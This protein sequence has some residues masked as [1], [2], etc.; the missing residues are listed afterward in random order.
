[1]IMDST[2]SNQPFVDRYLVV[3]DFMPDADA[4]AMRAAIEAHFANP[5]R[6]LPAT[7]MV[8]NYWYVPGLYTYLRAEPDKVLGAKLA[9]AFHDRLA[10]WSRQTLGLSEVTWSC[11]SLYIPGCRQGQHN[12]SANGRFGF[13]YSL[14]RNDRKTGGGETLIW[15]EED[16]FTTRLQQPHAGPGFYEAIVPQFNR[17]LVFDDRVPHAVQLVEGGMNPIEGRIVLHGHLREAGPIVEGELPAEDVGEIVGDMAAD[18]AAQLG[19]ACELFHGLVVLRFVV[20]RDGTVTGLRVVLNRLKRL[21]GNGPDLDAVVRGLLERVSELA[22][23]PAGGTTQVALP[24]GFGV[25]LV[26]D[27]A[28]VTR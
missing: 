16:Y 10:S 14:T 20:T 13:V 24:V 19:A 7:H 12:N 17:L 21:A 15:R 28:P 23:P 26:P 8:W 1:M 4:A 5:A 25:D 3:D 6:H 9:R 11:L 18:F 2:F 27:F 22:F